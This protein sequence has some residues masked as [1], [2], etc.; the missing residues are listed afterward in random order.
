MKK[1]AKIISPRLVANVIGREK[2]KRKKIVST[3]GV[4]DLL[5]VGHVR[6]LESAKKLG[7]ILI[8][9]L[10]T[11]ASVRRLKGLDRPIIPLKHRIQM[12]A[13]LSCVDYVSYFKEDT[14][15]KW[16]MSVKPDVH[17]KGADR[18][19]HE[20]AERSLVEAMGGKVVLAPHDKKMSTTKI[21]ERIAKK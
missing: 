1:H 13:A 16:L 11:D 19:L 21:L 18:K 4:F 6:S 12:V 17:V 7:D 3:N 2:K 9:G 8:V 10:N 5:H 14:P 15:Q 20:V